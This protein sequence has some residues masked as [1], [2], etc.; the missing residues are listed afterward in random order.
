MLV[1][2]KEH[3]VLLAVEEGKDFSRQVGARLATKHLKK[4][5]VSRCINLILLMPDL[6]RT[7]RLWS[8]DSRLPKEV[9][10]LNGFLLT[11]L[12]YP[13]DFL[14][15][16]E[17]GLFGYIDDAYLIGRVYHMA[18][19]FKTD[20]P[21]GAAELSGTLDLIRRIIPKESRIIDRMI[22]EIKE[23]RSDLFEYMMSK[24]S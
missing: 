2:L 10:R 14:P 11:Y 4:T 12:Y 1:A 17:H 22:D 23:G 24:Q 19:Q 7:V 5:D 20:G 21:I 18:R 3:L 15:E 6:I 13:A 16:H 9:K 8:V